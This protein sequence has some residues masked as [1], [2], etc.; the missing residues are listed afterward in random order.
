[1]C[2]PPFL[3]TLFHSDIL[4]LYLTTKPISDYMSWHSFRKVQPNLSSPKKDDSHTN[5]GYDPVNR[6]IFG[7]WPELGDERY[8]LCLELN[9]LSFV[10]LDGS[11]RREFEV[12]CLGKTEEQIE[13]ELSHSLALIGF[14]T[15]SFSS[16]MHFEI[17]DYG[18]SD[19]PIDVLTCGERSDGCYG[20]C[21]LL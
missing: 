14:D 1:M 9:L 2:L 19:Q 16:P 5:M 3:N 18:L 7:R 20:G 17:P 8:M 11:Y 6:R 12:V 21:R 15:N 4:H 10:P 13:S